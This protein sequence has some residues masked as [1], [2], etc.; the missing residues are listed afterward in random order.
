MVKP[1]R[2]PL[3][4]QAYWET[5]LVCVRWVTKGIS[6]EALQKIKQAQG[7]DCLIAPVQC[8]V[9]W[10]AGGSDRKGVRYQRASKASAWASDR[11][12]CRFS[13][14]CLSR[15]PMATNLLLEDR[16]RCL[17]QSREPCRRYHVPDMMAVVQ[18]G[19]VGCGGEWHC[20]RV[21]CP[22]WPSRL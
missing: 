3:C 22:T 21:R 11:L 16:L 7:G 14:A 9:C 17:E 2:K 13:Q 18:Q 12:P 1:K 6:E 8:S 19:G 10:W 5:L 4:D 20:T 15:E